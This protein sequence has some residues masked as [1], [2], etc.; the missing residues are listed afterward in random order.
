MSEEEKR[1]YTELEY[2]KKC[3]KELEVDSLVEFHFKKIAIDAIEGFI[4]IRKIL[5]NGEDVK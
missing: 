1:E 5:Q 4:Q 3:L 2:I